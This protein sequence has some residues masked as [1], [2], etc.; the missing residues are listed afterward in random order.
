MRRVGFV[1]L[2]GIALVGCGRRSQQASSLTFDTLPDSTVA[3]GAPILTT[4]EPYRMENGAVRVR[5]TADLP[6]GTRLQVS[7][8]HKATHEMA[9]R[10]QVLLANHRF[11]SPPIL[12]DHGPLP[13]DDYRFEVLAHFD[14]LWQSPDVMRATHNGL[15]LRGPGVTR[16]RLG[17]A[18]FWLERE[19]RL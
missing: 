5:G 14:P 2:L 17:R 10:F 4:F 16:D 12:G 6:D 19:G 7:L 3:R 13:V 9:G 8:Y 1:A 11:D 15:S 18:A